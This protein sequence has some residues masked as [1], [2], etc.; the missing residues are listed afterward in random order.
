VLS[1]YFLHLRSQAREHFYHKRNK[2]FV[3]FIPSIMKA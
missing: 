3:L 1:D 2:T